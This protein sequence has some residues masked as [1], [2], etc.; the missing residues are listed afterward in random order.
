MALMQ[1][2]FSLV[3]DFLF[4]PT[5]EA[6]R[7]R[8][9]SPDEMGNIFQKP[10]PSP[11]PFITSLFS[12][13]DPLVKE[14]VV[15][16]KYKKNWH[17][18]TSAAILLS[19]K[20]SGSPEKVILIPIPISKKRRRERGFNQCE[21]IID[22]MCKLYP[23]KFEKRFDILLRTKDSG[24]Q[25]L[26]D[27]AERLSSTHA[28]SV[29]KSEIN[30]RIIII[31]DVTTTGSTLKEAHETLLQAGYENVSALTLAH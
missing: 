13:K 1:S 21:L 7:L 19:K 28:F 26:K 18:I 4:P 12:Y 25:K 5:K 16:I 8:T 15:S 9:L 20:L 3:L 30:G 14:L 10:E 22:E 24:E 6:L 31:D 17:A 27:R 11:L 29:N 2:L 23:D